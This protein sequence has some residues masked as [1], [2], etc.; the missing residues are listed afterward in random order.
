MQQNV[1]V[2]F[3]ISPEDR[4]LEGMHVRVDVA[5]LGDIRPDGVPEWKPDDTETGPNYHTSL[6]LP[7]E[8]ER[9][10]QDFIDKVGRDIRDC[11]ES[12]MKRS[13]VY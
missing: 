4:G 11:V 10:N 9:L 7:G 6:V 13:L 1:I 12:R 8:A 5:A 3:K 2:V